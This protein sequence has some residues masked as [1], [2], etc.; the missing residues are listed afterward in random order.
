[1]CMYAGNSTDVY[2]VS[3]LGNPTSLTILDDIGS[4]IGSEPVFWSEP[5]GLFY[6]TFNTTWR[7]PSKRFYYLWEGVVP[8]SSGLAHIDIFN[9]DSDRYYYN[10]GKKSYNRH[11][12]EDYTA[13]HFVSDSGVIPSLGKTDYIVFDYWT[14]TSGLYSTAK[15][16][17]SNALVG[18]SIPATVDDRWAASDYIAYPLL[19]GNNSLEDWAAYFDYEISK[20]S[21]DFFL[22]SG[23]TTSAFA[24]WAYNK[25]VPIFAQSNSPLA[26]YPYLVYDA[27]TN[28]EASNIIASGAALWTNT[29]SVALR[30]ACGHVG[31]TPDYG[32]LQSKNVIFTSYQLYTTFGLPAPTGFQSMANDDRIYGLISTLTVSGYAQDSNYWR[33]SQET[34]YHSD[35]TNLKSEALS[36]NP[37][38]KFGTDIYHTDVPEELWRQETL[39]GLDTYGTAVYPLISGVSGPTDTKYRDMWDYSFNN[40]D[41]EFFVIPDSLDTA[42]KT[43][44]LNGYGNAKELIFK[45]TTKYT[46]VMVTGLDLAETQTLVNLGSYVW[47]DDLNIAAFLE[48]GFSEY[49]VQL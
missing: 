2:I 4:T 5:S 44:L 48:Q 30:H 29:L 15:Q 22:L 28:E 25:Q 26:E 10:S 33:T 9:I 13:L 18:V 3:G 6:S 24:D 42:D 38:M 49:G 11:I 35:F 16:Y 43:Y 17:H 20:H 34:A 32:P 45:G 14:Y 12:P 1:M 8:Y 27:Q 19:S 23:T 21:A 39:S 37:S 47:T 46:Q 31:D 36:F 7:T 40:L 41:L